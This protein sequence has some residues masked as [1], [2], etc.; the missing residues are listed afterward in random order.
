MTDNIEILNGIGACYYAFRFTPGYFKEPVTFEDL[1]K[2]GK[3]HYIITKLMDYMRP[4]K[5]TC[6]LEQYDSKGRNTSPHIHIHMESDKEL[7]KDTIQ[8]WIRT[9]LG[10]SGNKAYCVQI[11][12]DVDNLD[13]WFRYPLKEKDS[14]RHSLGFS[15]DEIRDMTLLAQDERE[16]QVKLNLKTESELENKHQFRDRMFKYLRLNHPDVSDERTVFGLIGKF[17]QSQN[18]MVPFSKLRDITNDWLCHA[19]HITFDSYFDKYYKS[20]A[21]YQQQQTL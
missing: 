6:S 7:K 20:D 12:M 13:R 2:H 16:Q 19:G 9:E 1:K 8:K 15:Q 4:L 21:V 17:Y 14:P 10:A 18:K 3:K 5:Y 11:F